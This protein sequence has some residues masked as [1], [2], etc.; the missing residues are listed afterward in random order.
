MR[1]TGGVLAAGQPGL[2]VSG[3]ICCANPRGA[4]PPAG[5]SRGVLASAQLLA[6]LRMGA[7]RAA[8][9]THG[10]L[11]EAADACRA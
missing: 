6:S 10:K 4:P 3:A 8:S 11:E 7:W 5:L 1:H 2:R 9:H